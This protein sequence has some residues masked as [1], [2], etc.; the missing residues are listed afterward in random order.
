[1]A[2][3]APG[4]FQRIKK[5]AAGIPISVTHEFDKVTVS[6]GANSIGIPHAGLLAA[7]EN[8][9]YAAIDRAA[10]RAVRYLESLDMKQQFAR[11]RAFRTKQRS[12]LA[13]A[14]VR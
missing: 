3:L 7:F 9:D 2:L 1:M 11:R 6:M 12:I 4:L 14:G 5:E 10:V 8:D 13:R